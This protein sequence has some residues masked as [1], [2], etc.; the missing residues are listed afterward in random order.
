[1]KWKK[2]SQLFILYF[3]ALT[4]CSQLPPPLPLSNWQLIAGR[5]NGQTGERPILY[6]V[7]VPSN[8]IRKDSQEQESLVDTTKAICEFYINEKDQ[9]IRLTIHTF[10]IL[11]NKR[12]H[13]QAQIARWKSQF[14]ELDLLTTL[15]QPDS[16][17]GF[18]GLFFE[19]QG[20][21]QNK[22]VKVMGWSMQLASSYHRQL[23]LEKNSNDEYKQADYT[24]KATGHPDFIN[25]HRLSILK[26]ANSFELI[27]ELPPP[28]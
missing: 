8:W 5:D 25:K 15:V 28:L 19:G 7:L 20:L 11:D 27:D 23:S 14:E 12:I 26:F 13:P 18:S 22:P 9:E 4:G 10:P 16:H 6:R 2:L 21:L 1:M 17:G 24:I 3:F